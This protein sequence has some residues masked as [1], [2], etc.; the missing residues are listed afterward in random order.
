MKSIV[1][2]PM[3]N[4]SSGDKRRE[5][6]KN[7]HKSYNYVV[8]LTLKKFCQRNWEK[9]HEKMKAVEILLSNHMWSIFNLIN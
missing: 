3:L 1:R 8:N 6:V 9:K 7:S 5:E 2:C 4:I